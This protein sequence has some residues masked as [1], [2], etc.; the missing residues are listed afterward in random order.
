MVTI[1]SGFH[2]STCSIETVDS[3]PRV[4]PA[5]FCANSSIVSTLIE[6][7]RPVSRPRGPRA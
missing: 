6:P 2:S 3:P 5:T 4:V 1:T 7:P